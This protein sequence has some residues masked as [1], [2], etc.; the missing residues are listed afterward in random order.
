MRGSSAKLSYSIRLVASVGGLETF[1]MKRE[2]N[3]FLKSSFGQTSIS[4]FSVDHGKGG[5]NDISRHGWQNSRREQTIVWFCPRTTADPLAIWCRED[6]A[7]CYC[8]LF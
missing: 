3:I 5:N 6:G 2:K 7:T 4:R 8:S 1:F